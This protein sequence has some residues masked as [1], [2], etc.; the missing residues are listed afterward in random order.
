M[1]A[2][3]NDA[4]APHPQPFSPWVHGAKGASVD[5]SLA[6]GR[7]SLESRQRS[8]TGEYSHRTSPLVPGRVTNLTLDT[9]ELVVGRPH[10]WHIGDLG[11]FLLQPLG[12]KMTLQIWDM[13]RARKHVIAREPN[14]PKTSC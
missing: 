5:G 6:C 3:S 12:L 4:S 11:S 10:K 2:E 13:I 7:Y 8:S 14:R 9:D 1:Q